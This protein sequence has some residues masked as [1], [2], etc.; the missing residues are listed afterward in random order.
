MTDFNEAGLQRSP[1]PA[2]TI[3]VAEVTIRPGGAGEDGWLKRSKDGRSEALDCEFTV[4]DG[5]H[6]KRKFWALLTLNGSTPGHDQAA[7]ISRRILRALL[8]SARGIKPDDQSETARKARVADYSAFDGLRC[9]VRLGIE[10]ARGGFRAKNIIDEVITPDA[11]NWR[12]IEQ[13]S[14][15]EKPAGGD[16]VPD[17]LR[18]T[19]DAAQTVAIQKPQWAQ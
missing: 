6:A 13:V 14:K 2:G 4:L 1:I 12:A 17:F 10:P 19:T 15:A 18:R 16:G 5:E 9:M 3:V 11:V 7:D 8:E